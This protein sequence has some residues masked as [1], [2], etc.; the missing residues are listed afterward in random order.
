MAMRENYCVCGEVVPQEVMGTQ[1]VEYEGAY[2]HVM[3]RGSGRQRV[4]H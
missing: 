1:R 4:F 2:Y 3:S